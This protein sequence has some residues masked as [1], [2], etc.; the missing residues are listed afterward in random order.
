[1]QKEYEKR[2][3]YIYDRIGTM[4]G[5]TCIKPMG[6][7]YVFVNIKKTGLT[8]KEF[9]DRLL[10][11]QHVAVVPGDNFGRNA[12]GFIR[13]S[14]AVSM[15]NIIEGLHRIEGFLASLAISNNK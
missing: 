14:Y 11:E 3:N 15:E 10:E 2:R 1:M 4:E 8:S 5:I 9:C 7:F 6:A 13:I 12:E